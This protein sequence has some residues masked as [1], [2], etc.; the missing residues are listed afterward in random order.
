MSMKLFTGI[1]VL[2][3]IIIG[4]LVITMPTF[5]AFEAHVVNITATIISIDQPLI[6]P[7]G[8]NYTDTVS[9]SIDSHDSDAT[10]I[11]YT[12]TPGTNPATAEDPRCSI[13]PGGS[14]PVAVFTITEDTVVKA[15][16][17]DGDTENAHGSVIT[18]QVFTI[19]K[20]GGGGAGLQIQEETQI[21]FDLSTNGE[22]E[23]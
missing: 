8:G 5:F 10:H 20:S 1:L 9:V 18:T 15:I 19:T 17:C 4:C 2:K 13:P 6:S 3:I 14:K 22:S 11:F 7:G 21:F 23:I 12:N 16:A